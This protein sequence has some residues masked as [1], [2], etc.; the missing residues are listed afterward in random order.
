MVLWQGHEAPPGGNAP[1]A[2]YYLAIFDASDWR[3]ERGYY[4]QGLS[5]ILPQGWLDATH[6][7][8]LAPLPTDR[9]LGLVYQ[10]WG[11]APW[12]PAIIDLE[13]NEVR[14]IRDPFLSEDL[15]VRWI[16][17]AGNTVVSELPRTGGRP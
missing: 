10:T 17:A 2:D 3:V 8:G 5:Y 4:Q 6:V 9:T 15:E 16:L 1:G 14:F 11:S 7:V 13:T 12:T